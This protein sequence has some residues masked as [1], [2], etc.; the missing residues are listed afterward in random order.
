[1]ESSQNAILKKI[2]PYT[3]YTILCSF[4]I[5]TRRYHLVNWLARIFL[6]MK[7]ILTRMN[8]L[9]NLSMRINHLMILKTEFLSSLPFPPLH[10]QHHQ[11]S[12][13]DK[14]CHSDAF[15]YHAYALVYIDS[16][17]VVH[18]HAE[19]ALREMYHY[20]QNKAWIG[21]QSKFQSGCQVAPNDATQ[22]GCGGAQANISKLL[23]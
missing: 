16:V 23:W 18:H 4:S 5:E 14:V 6:L 17:L 10:S 7:I 20:F 3:T 12:I 11:W 2:S 21:W 19:G 8:L 9:K 1:M 15:M 22:L 13:K